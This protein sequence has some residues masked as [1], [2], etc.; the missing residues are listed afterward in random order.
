M[1]TSVVFII[2]AE[3]HTRRE[4]KR[5]G[6]RQRGALLWKPLQVDERKTELG[7]S[8]CCRPGAVGHQAE[9]TTVWLSSLS[10]EVIWALSSVWQEGSFF[11]EMQD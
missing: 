3:T 6:R 9:E 10:P 1:V 8:A 2:E 5:A 4:R 11:S 7:D